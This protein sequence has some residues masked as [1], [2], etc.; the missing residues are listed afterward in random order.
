V[1][2]IH[3]LLWEHCPDG[4]PIRP[5]GWVVEIATAR[6]DAA[7]LDASNYVGVDNLLPDFGGRRDS[8]YA[9]NSSGAIRFQPGDLLIGNIRPY[10]KKVWLADRIGGASPDVLTLSLSPSAREALLP[11]FLYFLIASDPFIRYTMQHAKGA[12]M[13]RGDKAATLRYPVPVPPLEVQR[14]IV[15][16]L[17]RFTELEAELETELEAELQA[18]RRQ[19][20]YYRDSLLT[21]AEAETVRWLTLADVCRSVS[22]GGTPL[23]TRPDFYGGNIPWLRTQEVVFNEITDTEVT[24]TE[25]GLKSSSARWVPANCVIVAISGATAARVAINKIPLTT[26]QHCLVLEIDEAVANYRFVYHW[27][28]REYQR[29]KA[30]GQGARSDLNAAIIKAFPIAIPRLDA[31]E[32]IVGMLDKFDALVNDLSIG[33]SAELAARRKQYEYYRDRLLTFEEAA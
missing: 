27:M 4:V 13:P 2:R 15:Q 21:F 7:T 26:N 32:R 24:I 12:K 29:L 33:L 8:D 30:M 25:L 28:S 9:A 10:L 6:V 19:Y 17:D 23:A 16:I 11:R 22:S 5:L 1:S 14:G 31:Q 18:R 3:D 20:A